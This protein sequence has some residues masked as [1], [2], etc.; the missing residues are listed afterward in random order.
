[1]EEGRPSRGAG[2]PGATAATT[3]TGGAPTRRV[4]AVGRAWK[5][6]DRQAEVFGLLSGGRSNKEIAAALRVAPATVERHVTS[7]LAKAGCTRRA[8]LIARLWAVPL[9]EDAP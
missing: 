6:T 3:V 8:E 5:L 4:A 2:L 7:I 9:Q 1:V